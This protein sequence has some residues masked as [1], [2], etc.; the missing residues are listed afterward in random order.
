MPA[1][2]H[3][4]YMPTPASSVRQ[5]SSGATSARCCAIIAW[6]SGA[7]MA[8]TVSTAKLIATAFSVLRVAVGHAQGI[9]LVARRV[10]G[11]LAPDGGRLRCVHRRQDDGTRIVRRA[12]DAVDHF[13]A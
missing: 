3:W 8:S 10:V 5:A 12:P 1:A 4:R 2:S 7:S 9:V 13:L 6:I 11:V